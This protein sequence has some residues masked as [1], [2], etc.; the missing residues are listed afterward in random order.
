MPTPLDILLDILVD[1]LGDSKGVVGTSPGPLVNPAKE[2]VASQLTV[3]ELLIEDILTLINDAGAADPND[4]PAT[5]PL[6]A[7]QC[8]IL[9]RDAKTESMRTNPNNTL[10]GAKVKTIDRIIDVPNGY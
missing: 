5:L 3:S 10:I 7:N 4:L 6:I 9:A 2:E 1:N 8:V